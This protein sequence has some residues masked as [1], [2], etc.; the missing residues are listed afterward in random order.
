M[1]EDLL[2]STFCV[3]QLVH[4]VNGKSYIG[5]TTSSLRKRIREHLSLAKTANYVFARALRKYTDLS[6]ESFLSVFEIRIL[7]VS[8]S[9]EMLFS[10]EKLYITH[11]NTKAPKG[12]NS[13][14]GGEGVVNAS[15]EVLRKQREIKLGPK[16]PWYGIKGKE[17]PLYGRPKSNE[18]KA[19]LRQHFASTI[20]PRNVAV[21]Q[22]DL[23]GK[24]LRSFESA[25]EA[26]KIVGINP[27][28]I[29][30]CRKGKRK[31]A[32][33]FVWKYEQSTD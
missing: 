8:S 4:K 19:K 31:T 16:N 25:A 1:P 24:W 11:H 10:R 2:D 14:S 18:H 15:E 32:G 9:K 20:N 30:E 23:H 27:N 5:V 7:E 26:G 12:Y 28:H 21:H 17:H 3:Y 6:V 33:G 29:C 22:F 13:T